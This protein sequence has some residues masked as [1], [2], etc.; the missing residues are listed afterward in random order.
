MRTVIIYTLLETQH[1][2]L[3]LDVS[4]VKISPQTAELHDMQIVHVNGVKIHVRVH[5]YENLTFI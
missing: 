4:I 1:S 2:E 3:P 5:K